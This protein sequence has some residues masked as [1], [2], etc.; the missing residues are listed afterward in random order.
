[1]SI[2]YEYIILYCI[3]KFKNVKDM[4]HL[5]TLI[6]EEALNDREELIKTRVLEKIE[7]L[8]HKIINNEEGP[9]GQS[10]NNDTLILLEEE[11]DRCLSIW[12]Y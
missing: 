6:L 10:F 9:E 11:I 7:D 5:K 3:K 1:M 4:K 2:L 8:R 12:Y